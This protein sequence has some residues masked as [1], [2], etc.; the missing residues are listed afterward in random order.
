MRSGRRRA[1]FARYLRWAVVLIPLAGIG[2]LAGARLAR[3][4]AT[5]VPRH[6]PATPTSP[7]WVDSLAPGGV[8]DGT[9]EPGRMD[10]WRF[11]AR[12]D[13]AYRA[14]PDVSPRTVTVPPEAIAE[15]HDYTVLEGDA[16]WDIALAFGVTVD[17]IVDANDHLASAD[18][19]DPGMVLCIPDPP[20]TPTPL[21]EGTYVVQVGDTLWSLAWEFQCTIEDWLD[22]NAATLGSPLDR[23]DVGQILR[24]PE[25]SS[26]DER[27]TTTI[28]AAGSQRRSVS[29]GLPDASASCSRASSSA[30]FSAGEASVS[31]RHRIIGH[32]GRTA[33]LE[34]VRC[35]VTVRLATCRTAR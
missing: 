17:A 4:W 21:P 27:P 1:P 35:R 23:L 31:C 6:T 30:R 9:S 34:K 28:G 22:A 12:T 2:Y 32:F 11:Y 5:P 13:E 19:I 15:C 29:K 24:V 14:L 18:A 8:A 7:T 26:L 10:R 20:P 3:F 16:L 33:A 25:H